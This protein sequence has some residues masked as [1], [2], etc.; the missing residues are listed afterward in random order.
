MNLLMIIFW[1]RE[2]VYSKVSIKFPPDI[3]ILM[4][5]LSLI[6]L[7]LFILILIVWFII[8][9]KLE[10]AKKWRQICIGIKNSK[11]TRKDPTPLILKLSEL[12]EKPF[13]ELTLK[14][15]LK[16]LKYKDQMDGHNNSVPALQ[17]FTFFLKSL[18]QNTDFKFLLFLIMLYSIIT[19]YDDIYIIYCIPL[20][21]IIVI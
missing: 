18:Y 9:G 13:S 2:V 19:V 14:D 12:I 7:G 6:L 3:K 11:K 15:K 21:S 10:I 16:I 20:F 8:Y 5:I 1:E 17:Y 4:Y